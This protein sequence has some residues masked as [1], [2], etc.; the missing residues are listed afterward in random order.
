MDKFKPF[1]ENFK[2]FKETREKH[3]KKISYTSNIKLM[4]KKKKEIRIYK[5]VYAGS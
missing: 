5:R 4:S 3:R 2:Y 1:L